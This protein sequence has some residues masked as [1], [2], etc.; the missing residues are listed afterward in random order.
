M[1]RFN[2]VVLLVSVIA[3]LGC[4]RQVEARAEQVSQPSLYPEETVNL[5][6][7]GY[8]YTRRYI[9]DFSINS[10]G[11]GNIMVST[12]SSGGGGTSCCAPYLPG[13]KAYKVT[14]RW[15]ADACMFHTYS[16]ATK[17]T[18]DEIHSFYKEIKVPVKED[19][20]N[21]PKYMEVHFY[22][23]GKVE[24]SVTDT[25]SPPRLRLSD[26]RQDRSEFPRCPGDKQPE[27]KEAG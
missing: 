11:G 1:K 15:Q 22:P 4:N 17:R 26:S 20:V 7:L 25:R 5:A 3:V 16:V 21:P 14:V 13:M 10:N 12:P 23:D 27:S 19:F 18:F 2:L 6:I 8:N 24:V 9:A